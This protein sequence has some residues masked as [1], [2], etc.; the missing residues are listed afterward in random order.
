MSPI[1]I[2]GF[3]QSLGQVRFKSEAPGARLALKTDRTDPEEF[4]KK[5]INEEVSE[6]KESEDI[7]SGSD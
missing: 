1:D 3:K 6:E 4:K 7:V 5:A 2:P